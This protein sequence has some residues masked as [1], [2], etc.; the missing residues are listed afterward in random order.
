MYKIGTGKAEIKCFKPGVG[1][2]GYGM[3]HHKAVEQESIVYARAFVVEH[4]DTGSKFAFVNTESAF[5]TMAIK[6]GV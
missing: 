5:V 2:M 6:Q 4:P 1:M 3:P